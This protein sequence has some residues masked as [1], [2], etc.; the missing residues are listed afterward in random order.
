MNDNYT[1]EQTVEVLKNNLQ[2]LGCDDTSDLLVIEKAIGS[3]SSAL[4]ELREYINS[5][6]FKS[7]EEEI[8]FFKVTKPYVLGEYLYFSKL[9]EIETRRP[10][11]TVRAQKKY[12]KKM[13]SQAQRFFNE[14]PES[15][16]YYRSG[17][18]HFDEKCFVR[19]KTINCLNAHH[20]VVDPSFS[21]SHD[22]TLA[23]IKANEKIIVYCKTEIKQLE[24]LGRAAE[25]QKLLK[26]AKLNFRWT[27]SK[28]DLVEMIYG[29]RDTGAINNG[30]VEINDLVK[31]YEIFFNIKLPRFYHTFS[32]MKER[33]NRTSFLD[34]MK[35]CLIKRMDESD[36]K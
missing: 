18:T 21:T 19:A 25:L 12:L 1:P 11:T 10:V 22:Y 3:C 34:L 6:D 5:H 29:V 4:L 32:E 2:E 8:N 7:K 28:T 13:I 23:A 27:G 24:E 16:Q 26:Q 30:K 36:E 17:S 14:N 35:K 33:A 31:G 9:F 15:Y 20:F